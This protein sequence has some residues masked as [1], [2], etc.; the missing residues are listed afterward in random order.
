M[1]KTRSIHE[2]LLLVKTRILTITIAIDIKNSLTMIPPGLCSVVMDLYEN[3]DINAKEYD[4][5]ISFIEQ[6]RPKNDRMKRPFYWYPHLIKPRLN[7][8]NKYINKYK[9]KNTNYENTK[10]TY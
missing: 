10:Q 2:L 7:W 8:L 3:H 6:H 1:E 4:V 9:L 5:L